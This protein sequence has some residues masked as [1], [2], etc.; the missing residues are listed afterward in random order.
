MLGH[1]RGGLQLGQI[2][3]ARD[4]GTTATF[5]RIP[6]IPALKELETPVESVR[7]RVASGELNE[8]QAGMFQEFLGLW[9][10]MMEDRVVLES[11]MTQNLMGLHL[12]PTTQDDRAVSDRRAYYSDSGELLVTCTQQCVLRPVPGAVSGKDETRSKL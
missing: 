6:H 5:W 7:R 4:F 9:L 10:R 8:F 12:K 11:M 3:R 2:L 1:V